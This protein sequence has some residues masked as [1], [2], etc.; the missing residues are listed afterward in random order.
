MGHIVLAVRSASAA[1][2]GDLMY[3]HSDP[4]TAASPPARDRS[5]LACLEPGSRR[6]SHPARGAAQRLQPR[7]KI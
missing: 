7:G 2:P 6:V 4:N 5:N 1:S 3:P